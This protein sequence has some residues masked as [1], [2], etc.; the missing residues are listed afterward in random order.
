M[1]M[2]PPVLCIP[3]LSEPFMVSTDVSNT[4]IGAVLEQ[5][6]QLVAYF[7]HKLSL[8]EC[9]YLVTDNELLAIFLAYQR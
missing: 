5:C 6:G 2:S 9:N 3:V 8:M 1:L 4:H 7:L